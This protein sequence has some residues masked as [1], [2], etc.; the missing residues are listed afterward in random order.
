MSTKKSPGL[1]ENERRF[2]DDMA[3]LGRVS[4]G[5]LGIREEAWRVFTKYWSKALPQRRVFVWDA[6]EDRG[7]WSMGWQAPAEWST[8]LFSDGF[9]ESSEEEANER[10]Q[11]ALGMALDDLLM[12]GRTAFLSGK[13]G[14]PPSAAQKAFSF[15]V[16]AGVSANVWPGHGSSVIS[17][18]CL[19]R[20]VGV[21]RFLA[22]NGQDMEC[23][24][25]LGAD[26]RPDFKGSTLLHRVGPSLMQ[27]ARRYRE[28]GTRSGIFKGAAELLTLLVRV[29][30]NP[31]ARDDQGKTA[32]DRMESIPFDK[33][34][35]ETFK[36]LSARRRALALNGALAGLVDEDPLYQEW[37]KETKKW[38]S[39]RVALTPSGE[40]QGWVP[41]AEPDPFGEL[42][43]RA[44]RKAQVGEAGSV[45]VRVCAPKQVAQ[46][47]R[48]PSEVLKEAERE[49]A[50][51]LMV[52]GA[53]ESEPVLWL[54][55]SRQVRPM[56]CPQAPTSTP[57]RPRL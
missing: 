26:C 10:P 17:K 27:L 6:E 19:S 1:S 30:P 29:V 8:A 12:F 37:L 9:H 35:L 48:E 53:A 49:D 40:I 38:I 14:L 2:L 52:K 28:A 45:V 33:E 13:A 11:T 3:I 50:D 57:A 36:A 39:S 23:R 31:E 43:P 22:K 4:R 32:L 21:V 44:Y 16:R 20:Q 34:L 5:D 55:D 15:L 18:A 42:W 56:V 7:V 25:P 51:A 47:I 24:I 41:L 46:A 54:L